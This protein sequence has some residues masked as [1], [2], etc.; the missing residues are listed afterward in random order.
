M[1]NT[2]VC[3]GRMRSAYFMLSSPSSSTIW[4]CPTFRCGTRVVERGILRNRESLWA[5][6]EKENL[7]FDAWSLVCTTP[8]E[9]DRG[10]VIDQPD[11]STESKVTWI[12]IVRVEFDNEDSRVF[13]L[14]RS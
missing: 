5:E 1:N 3:T 2:A 8:R 13:R 4:F 7:S 10:S 14:G 9:G 12:G 6:E 11:S